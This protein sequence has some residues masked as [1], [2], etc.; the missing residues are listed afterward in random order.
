MGPFKSFITEFS[1]M[2]VFI[3]CFILWV[4]ISCGLVGSG[5]EIC[6]FLVFIDEEIEPLFSVF[7]KVYL[8]FLLEACLCKIMFSLCFRLLLD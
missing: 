2:Y 7:L 5:W 3:C 6:N 1:F 4:F 8:R